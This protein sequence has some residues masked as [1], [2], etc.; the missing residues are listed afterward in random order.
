MVNELTHYHVEQLAHFFLKYNAGSPFG[1]GVDT[2]KFKRVGNIDNYIAK[3]NLIGRDVLRLE[4]TNI[5][6]IRDKE[7]IYMV[8]DNDINIDPQTLNFNVLGKY[9]DDER[10]TLPFRHIEFTDPV[11]FTGDVRGYFCENSHIKTVTFENID[12]DK[13]THLNMMFENC[14][15]LQSVKFINCTARNAIGA[16]GMFGVCPVL[17][18]VKLGLTSAVNDIGYMF[19]DCHSL[20]FVS[21]LDIMRYAHNNDNKANNFIRI[22]S[23][24]TFQGCEALEKIV[25]PS[26]RGRKR[27]G[28]DN[29]L[30]DTIPGVE[31]CYIPVKD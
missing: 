13:T 23:Q 6:L 27:Y 5:Y 28:Y 19:I 30:K 18:E 10:D 17:K 25:I 2:L 7:I 1:Y 26:S 4:S 14:S 3:S 24:E 12:F 29:I 9:T 31:V 20:R 22:K 16:N 21:L 15:A 8:S 11:K